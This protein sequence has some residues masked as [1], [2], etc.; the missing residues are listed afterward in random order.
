MADN[1]AQ[2]VEKI[3]TAATKEREAV[4]KLDSV[5]DA[6]RTPHIKDQLKLAFF[7]LDDVES[8]LDIFAKNAGPGYKDW[9]YSMAEHHIQAAADL[10]QRVQKLVDDYG[11]DTIREVRGV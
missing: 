4:K 11:L 1:E 6:K 9:W 8:C 10:R 2:R 3:R 7:N 5:I